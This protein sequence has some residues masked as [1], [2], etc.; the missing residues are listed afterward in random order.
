MA[1]SGTHETFFVLIPA[2]LPSQVRKSK[3]KK[4]PSNQR[5]TKARIEA[6][7]KAKREA[8]NTPQAYDPQKPGYEAGATQDAIATIEA[9]QYDPTPKPLLQGCLPQPTLP[10]T[11]VAAPPVTSTASPPTVPAASPTTPTPTE[12]AASNPT[13][14][15]ERSRIVANPGTPQRQF[16]ALFDRVADQCAARSRTATAQPT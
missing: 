2:C 10:T 15:A 11:L 4:C 7:L 16:T 6:F 3:N 13:S 1:P 5:R 9:L 8:A 14:S 12:P